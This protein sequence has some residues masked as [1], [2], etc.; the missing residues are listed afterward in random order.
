MRQVEKRYKL[1]GKTHKETCCFQ[2]SRWLQELRI[3]WLY[4]G[5]KLQFLEFIIKEQQQQSYCG[6]FL[7][8]VE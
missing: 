7:H 5:K 3:C 8:Q 4:C 2:L 6:I 1:E